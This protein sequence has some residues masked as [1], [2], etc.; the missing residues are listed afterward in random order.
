MKLQSLRSY[1]IDRRQFITYNNIT[2]S[3]L[4]AQLFLYAV[5][6]GLRPEIWMFLPCK[7]VNGVWEVLE[8]P[9]IV[10]NLHGS[11]FKMQTDFHKEK[12]FLEAQEK[13]LFS[14]FTLQRKAFEDF[15][16]VRND[17]GFV[18][19]KYCTMKHWT[20]NTKTKTVEDLIKYE[21]KLTPTALKQLCIDEKTD[22]DTTK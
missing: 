8:K 6:L 18:F 4:L 5:F 20:I 3:E 21:V 13:V 10:N 11:F 17:K 2:E 15:D 19:K 7:L 12:E 9:N 22:S 1:T 16:Y 14:G